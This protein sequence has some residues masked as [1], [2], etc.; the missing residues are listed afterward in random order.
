LGDADAADGTAGPGDL[1][2]RQFRLLEPDA[3]E[4]GVHAVAIGEFAYA[5]DCLFAT[6]ADDV[7]C[8]ELARERDPVGMAAKER[9]PSERSS[10][11]DAKPETP[12]YHPRQRFWLVFALFRPAPFATVRHRL[13]PRAP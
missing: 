1:D 5:L 13:Q 4:D 2:C 8:A 9:A 11:T 12:P 10:R 6:L 3:L 7:G